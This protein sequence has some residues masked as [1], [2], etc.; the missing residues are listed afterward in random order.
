[1]KNLAVYDKMLLM[2]CP[3]CQ[4]ELKPKKIENTVYWCCDNCQALWFE[5]K[6]SDFL[7]LEETKLLHKLYPK[8]LLLNKKYKCPRCNKELYKEKYQ[9]HCH[10]C[11]GS[12]TSSSKLVEEKKAYALKY[13]KTRP[14]TL[15]QIKSVIVMA[16]L[17]LFFMLNYTIFTNLGKRRGLASQASEIVNNVRIQTLNNQ[18][19]MIFFNT[20]NPYISEAQFHNQS[21][22]WIVPIN[23][24]PGLTHFLLIDKPKSPTRLVIKI[25]TTDNLTAETKPIELPYSKTR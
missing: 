7:T 16:A 19:V 10:S 11:G 9:F 20:E 18:Q 8:T 23:K 1:M 3:N 2:N 21:R 4:Y 24:N 6:E 15:S 17:A 13:K 5:N 12:L 22:S 14:I 25:R